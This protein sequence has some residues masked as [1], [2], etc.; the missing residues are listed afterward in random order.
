MGNREKALPCEP[1]VPDPSTIEAIKQAHHGNLEG[2]M[3]DELQAV[4]GADH[5][6][7]RTVQTCFETQGKGAASRWLDA[8]WQHPPLSLRPSLL[9]GGQCAEIGEWVPAN[10]PPQIVQPIQ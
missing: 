6:A 2:V 1:L 10:R 7:D 8:P 3:P 5:E 4:L 9:L